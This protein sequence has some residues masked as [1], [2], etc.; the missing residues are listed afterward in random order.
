[1]RIIS[2]LFKGRI[3]HSFQADFIRPMTDRVKTSVFN[4]LYSRRGGLEGLSVLDLFSGTG[5]LGLESYSRGASK[6]CMVDSHKKSREIIQKN[7]VLLKV[8][9]RVQIYCKDVFRFLS[10]YTGP[11]FNL[12]FADPPFKKHWGQRILDS[13][14]S[15][16]VATNGSLLVL[17]ASFQEEINLKESLSLFT[18]KN[19]GD[20]KVL[21]YELTF[22][23]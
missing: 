3:L 1:M 10:T 2:G 19:F 6:V 9:S 4:T 15:S 14:A 20:K 12:I 5:S 23:E 16:Q 7:C 11:A 17:E 8:D 22:K 13:V 18:Q 21:F